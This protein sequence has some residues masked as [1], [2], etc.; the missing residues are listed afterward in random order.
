MKDSINT[1]LYTAEA[2]ESQKKSAAELLVEDPTPE[3]AL[4]AIQKNEISKKSQSE[5]L[6]DF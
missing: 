5:N 2:S 6:G 4:A 1:E 3:I